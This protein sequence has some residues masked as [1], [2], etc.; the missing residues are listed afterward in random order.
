MAAAL[1]AVLGGTDDLGA[2]GVWGGAEGSQGKQWAGMG[3]EA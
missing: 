3:S 1:E 2:G